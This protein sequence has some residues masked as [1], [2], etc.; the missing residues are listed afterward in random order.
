V[1]ALDC[2]DTL[3]IGDK[4]LVALIGLRDIVV[5]DTDDALLV[6]HKDRVQ[7]VKEIVAALK[8]DK[9]TQRDLAPQGVPALGQLRRHRQRRALPGQADHRETGRALSLQMHHHRA[10]HW[11]VVKGTARVT[12]GDKVFLLARTRAPTSR[13]AAAP[14]GKPRQA[15]AGA[16]RG[17]VR[18]LPG[19]GRHRPLRGRVRAH[20]RQGR[21]D[22][23]AT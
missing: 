8:R 3:A 22:A 5:V 21:R 13:S 7:E 19:R 1:I 4:R 9:R 23:D 18:Q 10:E 15:A 14:A 16:D 2:Q 6:A 17:A 12:C 11:I 20:R